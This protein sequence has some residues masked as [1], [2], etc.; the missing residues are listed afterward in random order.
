ML[1]LSDDL[2]QCREY[3]CGKLGRGFSLTE[4]GP[5]PRHSAVVLGPPIN[6][7]LGRRP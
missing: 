3:F 1:F 7:T 6:R 2:S 5:P 4:G